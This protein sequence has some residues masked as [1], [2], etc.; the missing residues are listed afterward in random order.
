VSKI[1]ANGA[2]APAPTPYLQTVSCHSLKDKEGKPIADPYI[3]LAARII[4]C[5]QVAA[6]LE[7]ISF[8]APS[9]TATLIRLAFGDGTITAEL[10]WDN[11]KVERTY[12][13]RDLPYALSP[14]TLQSD[15]E[16]QGLKI[17]NVV[18][19]PCDAVALLQPCVFDITFAADADF[20]PTEMETVDPQGVSKVSNLI[21]LGIIK[22]LSGVTAVFFQ[23]IVFCSR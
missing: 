4:V 2:G 23:D 21:S 15:L 7:R 5:D 17:V 3:T 20:V 12:R 10:Q 22:P 6:E 18:N 9:S 19:A 16:A 13:V 14:S 1:A 11:R 8:L